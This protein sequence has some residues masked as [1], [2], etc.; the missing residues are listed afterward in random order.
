MMNVLGCDG[1]AEKGLLQPLHQAQEA[2][3]G[4]PAVRPAGHLLE[5]ISQVQQG[6]GVEHTFSRALVFAKVA[7]HWLPPP[8]IP[9]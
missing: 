2:G 3:P 5:S 6:E 1:T 4:R 8:P 9:K 7:N